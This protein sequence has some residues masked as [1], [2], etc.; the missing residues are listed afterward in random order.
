MK[1]Y[2]GVEVYFRAF[3]T[4]TLHGGKW[5]ASCSRCLTPIKEVLSSIRLDAGTMIRCNSTVSSSVVVF[6]A[7]VLCPYGDYLKYKEE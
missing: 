7:T 1:T 6:H 2:V 4:S 3:V 5:L